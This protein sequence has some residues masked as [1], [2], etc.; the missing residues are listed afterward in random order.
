MKKSSEKIVTIQLAPSITEKNLTYCI[1]MMLYNKVLPLDLQKTGLSEMTKKE[2]TT[3]VHEVILT[4]L[5]ATKNKLVEKINEAVYLHKNFSGKDNLKSSIKLK[6]TMGHVINGLRNQKQL[7][8]FDEVIRRVMGQNKDYLKELNSKIVK[9][10]DTKWLGWADLWHKHFTSKLEWKQLW[11]K[12]YTLEQT[13]ENLAL[14]SLYKFLNAGIDIVVH[15]FVHQIPFLSNDLHR[16]IERY[17]IQ[18]LK[19]VLSKE[20]YNRVAEKGAVPLLHELYDT[21]V[22][23]GTAIKNNYLKV[24]HDE[25]AK[26]VLPP[27]ILKNAYSQDDQIKVLGQ[28]EGE[29]TGGALYSYCTLI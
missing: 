15:E 21:L 11:E 8:E 26:H 5:G 7:G 29:S 13:T 28:S 17:L 1:N 10:T 19:Y 25:L 14:V 27:E 6:V 16:T 12:F 24:T 9:E 18:N 20:F 3:E 23:Q 22:T 4:K 2:I